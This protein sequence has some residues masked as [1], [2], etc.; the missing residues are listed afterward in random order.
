MRKTRPDSQDQPVKMLVRPGRAIRV[1]DG[2]DS[3]SALEQADENREVPRA[4]VVVPQAQR[5]PGVEI[6]QAIRIEEEQ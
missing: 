5:I 4:E 2:I 6:P 1:Q 3:T